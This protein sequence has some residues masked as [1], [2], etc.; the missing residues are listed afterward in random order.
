M[1]V[2]EL[3]EK[4]QICPPDYEVLV[5]DI[6]CGYTSPV[7][8]DKKFRVDDDER[9]VVIYWYADAQF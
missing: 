9:D 8:N 4:L 2:K 6:N 3:I 5:A 7:M 1:T